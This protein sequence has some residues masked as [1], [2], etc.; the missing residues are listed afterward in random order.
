M[1]KITVINGPNLN[2]LGTREPEIYG[3]KTLKS[4]NKELTE[5]FSSVSFDFFQSNSEAEL[6]NRIQEAQNKANGI[7]INPAAYSHYSIAI[8][9]A[10]STL[11]IPVIEVHLS[12]IASREEFRHKSVISGACKG[13]ISGLGD[14]G[15][16]L[17]VKA[18]IHLTS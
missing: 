3:T 14:F 17:A 2:L 7:I 8:R 15:Y 6:I 5:S 13:V 10:V 18:L 11:S 1:T 9:D 4:I 12:N 16:H